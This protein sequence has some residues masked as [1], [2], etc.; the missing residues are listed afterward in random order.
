MVVRPRRGSAGQHRRGRCRFV[1][2]RGTQCSA[3]RVEGHVATADHHHPLAEVDPVAEVHIQQELDGFEDTV[4]VVAR[5]VEIPPASS[6][7]A[8]EHRGVPFEQ[9]G[10]RHIRADPTFNLD[11]YAEFQDRPDFTLDELTRQPVFGDPEHHHAPEPRLTFIDGDR[12]AGQAEIVGGGKTTWATTDDA[13]RGPDTGRHWSV[14]FVPGGG[15][16]ETLDAEALGD[17]SLERSNRHWCV[18][19]AAPASGLTWSGAHATANRRKWVWT[20]CEQVRIAEA[21]FGDGRDVAPCISVHRAGGPARFVVPQPTRVGDD[22]PLHSK[23]LACSRRSPHSR[24]AS[25]TVNSTV[26]SNTRRLR[27]MPD[28]CRS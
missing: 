18:D 8:D 1:A 24:A 12:M 20:A 26:A 13:D 25:A 23:R 27:S 28:S 6:A 10:E 4:E 22:R 14:A 15:T 2:S 5:D 9:L 17:E 21:T 11:I 3:S 16:R 19:L 7:H